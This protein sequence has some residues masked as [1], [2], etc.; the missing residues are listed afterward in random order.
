MRQTLEDIGF[1]VE[2]LEVE[3][4]ATRLTSGE[5]GGLKGW[6]K[7]MGASMLETLDDQTKRE[8]AVAEACEILST[9]ITREDGS[10]W[11][12]YVRLRGVARKL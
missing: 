9:V 8:A 1:Q 10:Q 3:Y 5:N 7:L 4:R 6:L 2:I 12:G 11:L